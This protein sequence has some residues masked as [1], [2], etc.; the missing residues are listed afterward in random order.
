MTERN[1]NSRFKTAAFED[2]ERGL[3][4]RSSYLGSDNSVSSLPPDDPWKSDLQ[5][6]RNNEI[7]NESR[8][9][10]YY[11]EPELLSFN[12]PDASTQ[13]LQCRIAALESM[14]SIQE[15][16]VSNEL[17]GTTATSED[18]R[19]DDIQL[20]KSHYAQLLAA[21]RRKVFELLV[22]AKQC[23]LQVDVAEDQRDKQLY[24]LQ[25]RNQKET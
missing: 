5:R 22:Q 19:H 16:H 23:E 14:L 21:W 9:S 11:K 17:A 3:L 1:T 2:T 6:T 12:Q 4:T 25:A 20:E 13:L 15:Q 8:S 10:D 24:T 7:R 18:R